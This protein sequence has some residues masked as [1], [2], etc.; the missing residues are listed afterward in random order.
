MQ[1]ILSIVLAH[2][3]IVQYS[4]AEPWLSG[5]GKLMLAAHEFLLGEFGD[6]HELEFDS[7]NVLKRVTLEGSSFTIGGDAELE[8]PA[9]TEKVAQFMRYFELHGTGLDTLGG[10]RLLP[11]APASD[12]NVSTHT[13]TLYRVK[14]PALAAPGAETPR[15]RLAVSGEAQVTRIDLVPFAGGIRTE[16]DRAPYSNLGHEF[17]V[18]RLKL[19]LDL[20]HGLS[21][22]GHA[23]IE[24]EKWFR[25]YGRPGSLPEKI[26]NF[27][28]ERNFLPG[29]QMLKFEP[30]LE[31][32][33]NPRDPKLKEDPARPGYPDPEFF[34]AHRAKL[35]SNLAERGYPPEMK[36]AMCF[37]D[38]P[39]FMSLH[40]NGRGTPRRD[41]FDAAAEMVARYLKNE[42]QHSGRTATWWEVK[43]EASIKSEWD[44][45]YT[46]DDSWGLLADL[47]NQIA[48]RVHRE[49][50]GVQIGGPASA[51]MQV[52]VGG[53]DLW[54]KQARFMDL[55]RG[56]LDVYTHHFYENAGTLGAYDRRATGYSNYLLGRLDA[57]LDL[58]RAHMIATDNVK[59]MLITECGALN[60]GGSNAD[61][62]LRLRTYSAYLTQM[63]ERPH[64]LDLIVPFIFLHAPWD[65]TNAHSAFIRDGGGE[66][67]MTP[68]AHFFDLWREFRG[69]RLPVSS[70]NKY[71]RSVACFDG[72]KVYVAISN[73]TNRRQQVDLG[74]DYPAI[75]R[76]LYRSDGEIH[77]MDGLEIDPAKVPLEVEETS[78][79]ILTLP[80]PLDPETTIER[81]SFYSDELV[82]GGRA[83][84]I[85]ISS[86]SR[87]R[88]AELRIGLQNSGGLEAPIRGTINGHPFEHDTGWAR[89]VANFFEQAIIPIDP[90]HLGEENR[91][92]LE[93][94][95]DG[96]TITEVHLRL[97]QQSPPP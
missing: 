87:I 26:E 60:I 86:P 6:R 71:V 92:E 77:Y 56:H 85:G 10:I 72:R 23:W 35:F 42:I 45:H 29:R 50:P 24:R 17:P 58:F 21:V 62:W 88:Y 93:G 46:A 54:A 91:V 78:I 95:P 43:N 40:P 3:L 84:D 16:F 13:P 19:D 9:G 14:V 44:Y 22:E 47:H 90:G 28:L 75:Q 51:W 67:E 33:Y 8:L 36:F 20:E 65:P 80:E 7:E 30:A 82:T 66:F 27:A 2:A 52:Q 12:L 64:Q 61:Y 57:I 39:S 74:V 4:A 97:D 83:F 49:V 48:D 5:E 18:E 32:G 15:F 76:R 81:R 59:P 89:D 38:Y 69:R 53:F 63:M 70:P 94:L 34:N 1:R 55:T 73:F 11:A 25:Y 79:V 31:R 68:C 96:T 41:K 37:N